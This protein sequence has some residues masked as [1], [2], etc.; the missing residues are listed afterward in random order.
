MASAGTGS[1]FSVD[2][3]SAKLYLDMARRAANAQ[4]PTDAD[5][6][7]LF[8]SP[9]YSDLF[10]RVGWDKTEFEGNVRRAFEIVYSPEQNALCD[11]LVAQID[12]MDLNG[13]DSELLFSLRQRST[14]VATLTVTRPRSTT[15]TQ[16]ASLPK[17]IT[18]L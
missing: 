4:M 8:A 12:S 1:K 5:W 14:S 17:Q 18:L 7:S 2:T 15:S 11:S 3:S 6:D 13:L 10:K 16:T 9:A